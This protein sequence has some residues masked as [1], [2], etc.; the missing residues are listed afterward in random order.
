MDLL[1]PSRFEDP[2]TAYGYGRT[3]FGQVAAGERQP[4]VSIAPS[5]CH[6][7]ATRRDTFRPGFAEAVR[8]TD[9]QGYPV[10]VRSPG[11]AT[12]AEGGTFGFSIIR[13]AEEE[14]VRAIV[15]RHDGA[16]LVLGALSGVG[17]R[18]A[19]LGEVGGE[20]CP[21][22]HSIRVGGW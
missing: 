14:I 4:T 19:E 1:M 2:V 8:A 21:G 12:A 16:A 15:E 20:F 5:T 22:D 17:V 13:P 9:E 3:I 7:G 11:G 6:V 18:V 10:F